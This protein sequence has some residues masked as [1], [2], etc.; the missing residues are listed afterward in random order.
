MRHFPPR[1][2]RTAYG[3]PA[4]DTAAQNRFAR[5]VKKRDSHA[6]QRCGAQHELIA[7]HLRPGYDV[8]AGITLCRPCHREVDSHAR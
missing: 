3:W 5:A 8:D 2:P 4:R 1:M 6:C 7:H